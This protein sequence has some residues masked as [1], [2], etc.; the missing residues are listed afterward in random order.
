[1]S[2]EPGDICRVDD[3]P[4]SDYSDY[5]EGKGVFR[6][7][8]ERDPDELRDYALLSSKEEVKIYTIDGPIDISESLEESVPSNNLSKYLGSMADLLPDED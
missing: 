8:P 5:E 4:Y 2:R 3:D 1:M 7:T 6:S